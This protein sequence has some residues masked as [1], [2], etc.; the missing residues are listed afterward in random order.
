MIIAE[1]GGKLWSR[2]AC[3]SHRLIT[4][5]FGSTSESCS[6]RHMDE[7]CVRVGVFVCEW[8]CFLV[9]VDVASNVAGSLAQLLFH[10]HTAECSNGSDPTNHHEARAHTSLQ[11]ILDT[12]SAFTC[13]DPSTRELFKLCAWIL[14]WSS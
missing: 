9:T 10:D 7:C 4:H 13:R 1:T 12:C 5:Q 3:F 14:Y 11:T 6:Y 8:S 2:K